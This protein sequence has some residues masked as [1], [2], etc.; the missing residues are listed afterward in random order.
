MKECRDKRF[1]RF[2]KKLKIFK[3]FWDYILLT[4]F[5]E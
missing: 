5:K 3:S 4:N 2:K 1:L